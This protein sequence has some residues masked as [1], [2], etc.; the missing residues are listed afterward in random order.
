MQVHAQAG[1]WS[2]HAHTHTCAHTHIKNYTF[3]INYKETNK[4]G[5]VNTNKI[6]ILQTMNKC[7][8][9]GFKIGME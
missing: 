9:L 8:I 6:K 5:N 1:V 3:L 2:L 4:T 7:M